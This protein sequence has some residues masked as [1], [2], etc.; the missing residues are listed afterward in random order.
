[1]P[2]WQLLL[3]LSFAIQTAISN[4]FSEL[5]P[6]HYP[7]GILKVSSEVQQL[8]LYQCFIKGLIM[9]PNDITKLPSHVAFLWSPTLIFTDGTRQE[10]IGQGE[11]R[12]YAR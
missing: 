3:L 8:S 2:A 5:V 6:H 4:A 1:M 12:D 11:I 7:S 10:V 9:F